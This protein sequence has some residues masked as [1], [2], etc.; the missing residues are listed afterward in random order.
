MYL[1]ILEPKPKKNNAFL[2]LFDT[3]KNTIWGFC[4]LFLLLVVVNSQGKLMKKIAIKS[5]SLQMIETLDNYKI[6]SNYMYLGIILFVGLI[7]QWL[8]L[9]LYFIEDILKNIDAT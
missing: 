7:G 3:L 9:Q 2:V 8:C 6:L 1:I 4:F 5:A